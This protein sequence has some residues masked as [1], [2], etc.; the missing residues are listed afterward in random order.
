MNDRGTI[1]VA[2]ALGGLAGNNAHGAGFLQAALD[3]GVEPLMISC[4]S[5]QIRWA[6]EYLRGP[7]ARNGASLRDVMEEM[8]A[9]GPEAGQVRY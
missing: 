4:T 8:I 5:G 3:A 6:F 2:F 7:A 9:T 1:T